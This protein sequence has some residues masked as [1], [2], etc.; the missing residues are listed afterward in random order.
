M[1]MTTVALFWHVALHRTGLTWW[2]WVA[3]VWDILMMLPDAFVGSLHLL[4]D[5]GAL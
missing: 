3:L 4:N 5:L 2:L 1:V